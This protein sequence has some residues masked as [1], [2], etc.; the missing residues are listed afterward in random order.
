M[1]AGITALIVTLQPV[2]TNL[3]AGPLLK[4]H[5]SWKQWV[6]TLLGLTGA[7]LVLGFDV[8]TTLPLAGVIASVISLIAI[9]SATIWQKKLT[10]EI[11]LAV[12]NMYQFL[13]GFVFHLLIII[14]LTDPFVEFSQTFLFAMG[15]QILVVSFGAYTILMYLIKNNCVSKK[16]INNK[17]S[18]EIS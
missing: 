16:N 2:L 5:I 4:E 11:P 6:G 12:S 3:L 14:F 1:P 17:N 10:N 13:G 15:Y 8:G 9:T 18:I 7:V